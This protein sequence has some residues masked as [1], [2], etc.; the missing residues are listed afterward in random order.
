[1][2]CPECRAEYR[3]G[4]TVCS[5]CKV[6]LVAELEPEPETEYVELVTLM[7][8]GDKALAAV[9]ESVLLS[10]GITY[11]VAGAYSAAGRLDIANPFV[12]KVKIHVHPEDLEDAQ[13]L[14]TDMEE[15]DTTY[16]NI[17]DELE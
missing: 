7:S 17:P 9:V 8:T 6:D 12:E 10:A 2:F 14:L 11:Y 5:D 15:A 3:E 1:M 16:E 13:A 4:Y